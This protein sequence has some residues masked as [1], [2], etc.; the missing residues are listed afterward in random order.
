LTVRFDRLNSQLNEAILKTK[1]QFG[2]HW[3]KSE[4]VLN[5]IALAAELMSSDR[6]LEIGPGM[7]VLTHR[8]IPYSGSVLSVEVD[9][10]LCKHLVKQF[11]DIDNFLL[12][13][14]DFLNLDLDRV[15]LDF[16]KFQ[17]PNKVV[18]NIP[19]NITG[20][21]LEKLLGTISKPNPA[22]YDSIVLLVQREVADRLVAIPDNKDFGA[23]TVR[24]GYLADC[25]MVCPVKAKDFSPP[26]KVESAV[27][28]I[29]PRTFPLQCDDTQLLSRL[30]K[31]GFSTR[32]KMLRNNLQSIVDRDTLSNLFISL[33]ISPETRAENVSV[34]QW[35]QLTN[36]ITANPQWLVGTD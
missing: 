28:K 14:G 9:R 6:I 15:L 34:T 2:Q 13:E 3:L 7:G 33:D 4:A 36:Q 29:T 23:L 12:L 25:Q 8:L 19:Y 18:A 16:P 32:R 27:I 35:I 11:G 17:H 10:D 21:I 1:R 20:P 24:V 31:L 22:P 30:V 5:E 26:P